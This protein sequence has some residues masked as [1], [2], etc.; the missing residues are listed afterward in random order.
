MSILLANQEN[1]NE[2]EELKYQATDKDEEE[3]YLMYFLHQPL[4]EIRAMT[5]DYRKWLLARFAG[6]KHLEREAMLQHQIAQNIDVSK[7][8]I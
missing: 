5:D 7:L 4:S 6:Q 1:E 3:F 8:K 2:E